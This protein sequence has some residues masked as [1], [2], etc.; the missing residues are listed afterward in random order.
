MIL[1][2]NS[3]HENDLLYSDVPTDH[4]LLKKY[5]TIDNDDILYVIEIEDKTSKRQKKV[6]RVYNLGHLPISI[7]QSIDRRNLDKTL[8]EAQYVSLKKRVDARKEQTY[9]KEFQKYAK[10]EIEKHRTWKKFGAAKNA[11]NSKITFTGEDVTF[12]LV[13]PELIER[14]VKNPKEEKKEEKKFVPAQVHGS[15]TCRNCGGTHFTHKCSNQNSRDSSRDTRDNTR[16]LREFRDDRPQLKSIKVDNIPEGSD[17]NDLKRL[18]SQYGRIAKFV[19]K[20]Y[21]AFVT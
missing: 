21:F 8:S 7:I 3:Y 15:V 13:H 12:E 4:K 17:Y 16:G 9:E 6:T 10:M 19:L 14:Y 1:K 11:D 18:F 20:S 2:M 5:M